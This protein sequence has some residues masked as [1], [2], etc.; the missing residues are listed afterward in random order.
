MN[1]FQVYLIRFLRLII[2]LIFATY[3]YPARIFIWVKFNL[4]RLVLLN[5]L[6]KL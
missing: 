5:M 2:R 4:Q 1:Y 3:V 6:E